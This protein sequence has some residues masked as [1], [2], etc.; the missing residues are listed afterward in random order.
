M[1]APGA[2]TEAGGAGAGAP[3]PFSAWPLGPSRSRGTDLL[4]W[5]VALGRPRPW[6]G[7][8]EERGGCGSSLAAPCTRWQQPSSAGPGRAAQPAASTRSLVLFPGLVFPGLGPYSQA[9]TTRC[10]PSSQTGAQPGFWSA[11]DAHA[12]QRWLRQPLGAGYGTAC[13][14]P[15]PCPGPQRACPAQ[16][17]FTAVSAGAGALGGS[18]GGSPAGL[19]SDRASPPGCCLP[20][21]SRPLQKAGGNEAGA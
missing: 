13:G 10:S 8:G 17:G 6:G 7:F 2:R 1:G 5:L 19:F 18:V 20:P 12:G 15:K 11:D 14:A 21:P 9:R 16:H 4:R 3:G